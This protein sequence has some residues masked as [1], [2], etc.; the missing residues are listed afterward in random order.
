M[1]KS[2]LIF[3]ILAFSLSGVLLYRKYARD[4]QNK[5]GSAAGRN[6]GSSFSSHTKDDDYEPYTK[7]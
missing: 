3:T 4:R 6:T 2:E 5:T 1:D 7:K